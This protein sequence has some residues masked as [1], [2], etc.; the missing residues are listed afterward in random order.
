MQS[1]ANSYKVRMILAWL[2]RP[3]R[4]VDIDILAGENRTPDF[5]ALNPTGQVPVLVLED[6]RLLPESG[7]ILYYLSQGSPLMPADGFAR[8]EVLRWMFFEQHS[9]EPSIGAARFWLGLVHGGRELKRNLI[10]EWEDR[11]YEALSVMEMHLDGRPF[12]AGEQPSVAD[13]ALYA[14][15]HLA[16][17]GG[18][19]LNDFPAVRAWLARVASQHDH[20]PIDWRPTEASAGPAQL[21]A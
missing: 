10:E 11:G 5:L 12:F 1:S 3:F 6:G 19:E 2:G 7:A 17:E 15:T 14:N 4:I 18:F 9:H 16:E 21:R 13:I 20:V 8:A